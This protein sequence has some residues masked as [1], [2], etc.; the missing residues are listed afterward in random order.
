MQSDDSVWGR[1]VYM[2]PPWQEEEKST[3]SQNKLKLN[4]LIHKHHIKTLI[5]VHCG[6]KHAIEHSRH[7]GGEGASAHTPGCCEAGCHRGCVGGREKTDSLSR[8]AAP[9]RWGVC[10]GGDGTLGVTWGRCARSLRGRRH[11]CGRSRTAW[12]TPERGRSSRLSDRGNQEGRTLPR[13]EGRRRLDRN[14]AWKS[15]LRIKSSQW[16]SFQYQLS[17]SFF[18]EP[19]TFK[20]WCKST[21]WNWIKFW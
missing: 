2:P 19:K 7:G 3:F 9:N 4:L 15:N 20:A 16:N 21:T 6:I 8:W 11:W 12:C 14:T 18:T 10:G 17:I 1:A 5:P 13:R